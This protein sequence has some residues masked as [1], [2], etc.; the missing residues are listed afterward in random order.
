VLVERR[1]L[2]L[3]KQPPPP[4]TPIQPKQ[5]NLKCFASARTP[6]VPLFDELQL[7]VDLHT[8]LEHWYQ[9][10]QFENLSELTCSVHSQRAELAQ[11]RAL[12]L[13]QKGLPAP[14]TGIAAID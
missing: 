14:F 13:E 4:R 1:A 3:S 8:E 2:S 6:P 5:G 10:Q 11:L 12:L 7:A 9:Q